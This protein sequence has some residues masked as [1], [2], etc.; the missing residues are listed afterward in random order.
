MK[1]Q[2]PSQLNFVILYLYLKEEINFNEHSD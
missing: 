1:N 2:L